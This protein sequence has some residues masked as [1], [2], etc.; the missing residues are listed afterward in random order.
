MIA[1]PDSGRGV[2][3]EKSRFQGGY[4]PAVS[5]KEVAA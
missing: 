4:I 5:N 1:L 3:R 2:S